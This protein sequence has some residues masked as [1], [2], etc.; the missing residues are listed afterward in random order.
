MASRLK[1]TSVLGF[2]YLDVSSCCFAAAGSSKQYFETVS[3]VSP[4]EGRMK[5][6]TKEVVK[7][8]TLRLTRAP[9][10]AVERGLPSVISDITGCRLSGFDCGCCS[11]SGSEQ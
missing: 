1:V 3:F 11:G 7:K 4:C 10:T 2:F 6:E 8:R 9:E 5:S